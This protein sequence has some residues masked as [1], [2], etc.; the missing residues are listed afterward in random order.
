MIT[1]NYKQYKYPGFIYEGCHKIY[2]CTEEEA[3][4][5][6]AY[7]GYTWHPIAE[8]QE[9]WD[10]SCSLR[11]INVISTGSEIASVV[12]QFEHLC[13]GVPVHVLTT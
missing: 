8:L 9:V 5:W 13:I 3:K 1:I 7:H 6:V 10:K 4:D 11:F 2:L 12:R